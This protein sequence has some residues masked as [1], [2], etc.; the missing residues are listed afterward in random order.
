MI[1]YTQMMV[2]E[3]I[4]INQGESEGELIRGNGHIKEPALAKE[5]IRQAYIVAY[6]RGW[7]PGDFDS[8]IQADLAGTLSGVYQRINGRLLDDL[9]DTS[10]LAK[11][12]EGVIQE[13]K[14]GAL[15]K[16]LKR[17]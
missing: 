7:R 8:A 2:A 15:E 10:D 5:A 11:I 4:S 3:R 17:S 13:I 12:R 6:Q 9:A 16:Y 1:E 14:S